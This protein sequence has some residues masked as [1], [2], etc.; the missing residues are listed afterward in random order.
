ME[1]GRQ[2]IFGVL[3]DLMGPFVVRLVLLISC[4]I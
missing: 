3:A 2:K 1:S 4:L